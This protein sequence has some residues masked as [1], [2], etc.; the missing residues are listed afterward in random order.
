[1]RLQPTQTTLTEDDIDAVCARIIDKVA[2]AT[3]GTLR[4]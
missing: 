1:V 2:K 3:G 4:G